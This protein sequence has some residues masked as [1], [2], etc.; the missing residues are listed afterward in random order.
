[1]NP[2]M[3]LLSTAMKG[4]NPQQFV[5]N[6]LRQQAG[7]NPVMSS[8]LQMAQ[9]GNRAGIEQLAKNIVQES[10]KDF[11]TEFANFRQSL[12]M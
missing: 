3:T 10:G 2:A 7:N 6:M 12:G 5:I 8:L 4:G 1:M 11:N 9:N